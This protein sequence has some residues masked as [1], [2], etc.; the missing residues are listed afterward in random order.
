M[1]VKLRR[2]KWIRHVACV[3]VMRNAYEVLVRKTEEKESLGISV[4]K[5]GTIIKRDRDGMD[6]IDWGHGMDRSVTRLEIKLP[7][8]TE[9]I[10]HTKQ[11]IIFDR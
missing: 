4:Y 1:M 11:S 2:I 5:W 3:G 9:Q 10:T 8:V 6:W 7:L